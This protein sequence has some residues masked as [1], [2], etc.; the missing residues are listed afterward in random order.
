M[1]N[2]A[3]LAKLDQLIMAAKT[4][5]PVY[6]GNKAVTELASALQINDSFQ[7]TRNVSGEDA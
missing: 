1:N 3:I 4:P 6:I 2:E 7:T 5:P